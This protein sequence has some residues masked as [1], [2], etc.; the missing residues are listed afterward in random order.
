M[1]SNKVKF[2]VV[3]CGAISS[4]H[5]KGIHNSEGAELVA[6]CDIDQEAGD[7]AAKEHNV[8]VYYSI[9]ELLK[10]DNI[11][12]VNICTP[13][14][15]HPEQ[16]IAAAKAGKHVFVEKPMAIHLKDIEPMIR[17]C[18]ENNVRLATVF[19]RR[20]S[21][22]ARYLRNLISKGELGKLSLCSA[23]AKI[24]RSQEY[25]DSAGWRGTWEY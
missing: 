25:Y 8:P 6:V 22:Q 4:V 19:P 10:Q 2:A 17:A 12:V 20:M 5:F 16:T 13:S 11:D 24:Y 15:L 21:P 7:K 3:G 1:G 9:E 14:Y 18:K 23:Y